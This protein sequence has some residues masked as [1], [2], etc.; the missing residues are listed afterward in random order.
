M[1]VKPVVYV[2]VLFIINFVI[3]YLLLWTTS[4]IC[5]RRVSQIRLSVGAFIGA[6]YAVVMFFPAFKIYYTFMSKVLFSF[7]II[8]VTFNIE[9]LKEFLKTLIIFYGVNFTFAGTAL[10][11]F[12]FTNV[13]AFTGFVMSNGVLYFSFPWKTL[14]ISGIVAYILIKIISHVFRRRLVKENMYVPLDIICDNKKISVEALIDTGN[15]L[16]DPISNFP[17]VVVEFDAIK[18]L[19]PEEVKK[20]FSEYRENDLHIISNIMSNSAW[21]SRFRLIPFSSLGKENGML[22]GFKPDE[23][24]IIE[25][26]RKRDIKD[27]IV[28][29][30]NHKLSKN[31]RYNA[32]LNPEII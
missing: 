3:N 1:K 17:V 29:I 26:N 14:L 13:G 11:L 9:K 7:V 22:I 20:I 4:K 15:S 21:V 27:I 12:Y 8:A 30:Y 32:L 10:G 25:D 6:I 31:D 5:R 16:Y 19:L 24:E 18:E 28:G 23:I 2:D